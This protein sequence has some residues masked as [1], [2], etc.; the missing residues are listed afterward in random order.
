M[1][2][3]TRAYPLP[4]LLASLSGSSFGFGSLDQV[5]HPISPVWVGT[6]PISIG[7]SSCQFESGPHLYRSAIFLSVQF[8]SGPHLYRSVIH[9]DSLS[10]GRTYI[11]RSLSCQF[12]SGPHLYRSAIILSVQFESGPHLYRSVI[13]LSD[14]VESCSLPSHACI[15][16]SSLHSESPLFLHF[17]FLE[18]FSSLSYLEL[19]AWSSLLF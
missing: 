6:A 10:R 11:D 16:E 14:W 3:H 7:H 13:V 15:V 1:S 4:S 18:S 2:C 8:E 12:E 19:I 5:I 9:H 17:G